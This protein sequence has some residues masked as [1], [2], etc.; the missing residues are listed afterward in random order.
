MRGS[1]N[2]V[3]LG[4]CM[5]KADLVDRIAG[6]CSISKAQA[7]TAID[8]TVDSIPAA[9]RKG[10]RGALIGLGTFSVSQRKPRKGRTPLTGAPIKIAPRRVAK[11]PPGNEL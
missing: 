10:D 3:V 6:A 9:L 2:E 7:T 1:R 11:F 8:T 4:E 5:N